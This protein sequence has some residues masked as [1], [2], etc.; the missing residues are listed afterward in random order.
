MTSLKEILKRVDE[1]KATL[2]SHRPLPSTS[3]HSIRNKL[4]L[5]WTYH[6]NAIEGNTLSLIETKVVVEDGITI[7]GKSIRE[8]LEAINHKEAIGFVE[9]MVDASKEITGWNIKSIHQL[10][11]KGIDDRIAGKYRNANVRIGGARHTPPDHV[12]VEKEMEN[13]VHWYKGSAQNMHPVERAAHLH[14]KFV[15]IHPFEDG[16]GRTARLLLNFELMK[17][18][19]PPAIIDNKNRKAYYDALDAFCADNNPDDFIKIVA[20][21]VADSLDQ[22]LELVTGIKQ[23]PLLEQLERSTQSPPSLEA[24]P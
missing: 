2:D 7:G 21:R 20:L 17:Q 24:S 11:L 13:L 12:H 1:R 22:Y 18:G 3:V 16:N 14:T 19:Y 23:Q 15:G 9:D 6:S 8:H 10:V 4:A 5:D